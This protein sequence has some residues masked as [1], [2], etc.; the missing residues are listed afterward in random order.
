MGINDILFK[1]WLTFSFGWGALSYPL[2]SGS[3]SSLVAT[4]DKMVKWW[5]DGDDNVESRQGV[6]DMYSCCA[7]V[8][9]MYS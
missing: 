8:M 5:K 4:E 1:N 3:T 6:S 9:I 7:K 2:V